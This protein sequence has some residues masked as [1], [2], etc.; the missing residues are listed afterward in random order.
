MSKSK[1]KKNISHQATPLQHEQEQKTMPHHSTPMK[2]YE[3]MTSGWIPYVVFALLSLGIYS[4]TFNAQF[5]LDDDIVI[6]KNEYVLQ[7]TKGMTD[8]FSKDLF[9]SFYKQMNTTAQLA[10]GRYRP[11]SVATFAIEQEFIGTRDN[12]NF[13]QNIWDTNQ[14][15]IE[16]PSEDINKDGLFNDKDFRSKGFGMRHINNV[17]L[18]IASVSFLFL[19]LSNVVFKKNKLLAFIIS[20]LFLAHPIHTEVVANVKS[21]DEIMSFLF[22]MLSLLLA[23]KYA[24]Q[25]NFKFFNFIIHLVFMCT[26]F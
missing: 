6:C 25:K 3:K 9:D 21:R 17:L 8:I 18:Y 4:N 22:M 19:F 7:G 12:A 2:W 16:D 24:I 1:K 13:E 5:A 10:G 14:N 26:T 11:L 15:G 23:H 20:L